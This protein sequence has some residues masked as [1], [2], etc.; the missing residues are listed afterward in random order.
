MDAILK[1]L[2]MS[3]GVVRKISSYLNSSVLTMLYLS[4]FTCHISYCVTTWYFGNKTVILNLQR[5]ANKFIRLTNGF[6][7]LIKKTK[8]INSS[9]ENITRSTRSSSN[10]YPKFCGINVTKQSM[11]YKGPLFWNKITLDIKRLKSY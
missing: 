7:M 4:M 8:S 9:A 11:K 1:R 2:C 10:L 5:L 6:I 3:L